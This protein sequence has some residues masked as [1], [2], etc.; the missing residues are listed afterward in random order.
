MKKILIA[1]DIIK[2][3]GVEKLLQDFV[4]RWH[5][6]YEITVL[7]DFRERDFYYYYPDNV[8]YIFRTVRKQYKSELSPSYFKYLIKKYL[9][10]IR[11]RYIKKFNDYDVVIA[12]KDGEVTKR[13]ADFK[14]PKKFSWY[15]T[16]Y[17]VYY[18]SQYLYG[19]AENEL[20]TLR[21]YTNV[22]CVAK[23]I[24]SSLKMVIGDAGNYVVKYN[25]LNV[26]K[27][28]Y[29]GNEPVIDVEKHDDRPLFVIVGRINYQKG[30]D[31]L[32]EAAHMLE[33]DGY[34][35]D[36]IVVGGVEEWSDEYNR[37]MRAK[38]RLN[39]KS[40]NFIGARS[41]PYKY[42]KM[43]DWFLSTSIFEGF[44]FVSQE[45]A[46]LDTPL[47]LTECSGVK[48]LVGDSEYGMVIEPSVIGIY[49]G[50]KKVIDNPTYHEHY[51]AKI[52]ERKRIIDQEK[53]FKEIEDL[54]FTD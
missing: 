27:I 11:F 44:S 3:G 39:V 32:L 41:N 35:F 2:G 10:A 52:M 21:K 53:R 19:S 29:D 42:M 49:E 23:D 17:N 6:N 1:N 51:K 7:S 5:D 48:E 36:V 50:M 8:K 46:L 24:E 26:D 9:C 14:V 18:Y 47:L 4:K 33:K 40:V 31:L 12:I 22:V 54:I 13:M 15:H 28:L 37:I 43:A 45:A 30:F 16:D 34:M 38:K 25:P 20:Q